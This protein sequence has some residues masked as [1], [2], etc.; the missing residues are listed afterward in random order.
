MARSQFITTRRIA[1][2]AGLSHS[3]VSLVLNQRGDELGIKPET[4][5]HVR[6]IAKRLNYTRNPLASGLK[7]GRTQTIGVMWILGGPH[8]SDEMTHRIVRRIQ[9]REYVANLADHLSQIKDTVRILTDFSRRRMDAVI[10]QDGDED[11]LHTP[12]ILELL[13]SFPAAVIV[14]THEWDAPCDLII[15]DRLSAYRQVAD[16]FADIGRRR[17]AILLP[18]P[19]SRAKTGAFLDQARARGMRVTPHSAIDMT[20]RPDQKITD[21]S[22]EALDREFPGQFPFDCLHC[23]T[24]EGAV[25]AMSWL[26]RRGIRIPHDVAI[27]G[28]NDSQFSDCLDPPLASV[29]RRDNEVVD[30]IEKL[31]FQRLSSPQAPLSRTHVAMRFLARASA[32]AVSHLN[33]LLQE[34]VS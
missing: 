1:E 20:P 3:T 5:N 10:M 24:D 26:R 15:H 16:H 12:E 33:H 13:K 30:A 34:D 29:A 21:A 19:G 22:T 28:F 2:E 7:G 23:S 11:Q 8:P 6:E 32:G 25:A 17:P 4:Q 9:D 27:S 31:V 18:V 14:S